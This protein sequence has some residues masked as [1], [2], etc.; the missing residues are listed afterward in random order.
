[1]GNVS[2]FLIVFVTALLSGGFA[3]PLGF[4]L[5]M[6]ALTTYFAAVAG[7]ATGMLVFAFVGGGLRDWIMSRLRDPEAATERVSGLLGDWGVKGLGLIGPIFPGVTVSVIT[8][9]ALG[10]GRGELIRWMTVGILALFAIYT[11]GLVILIEVF[12]V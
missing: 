5:E 10:A 4:L 11:V 2:D 7:A 12:N 3:I 9:L 8:G 1:M 6:P